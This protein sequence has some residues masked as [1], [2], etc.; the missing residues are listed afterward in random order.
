MEEARE[1]EHERKVHAED[2]EARQ[3]PVRRIAKFEQGCAR[4]EQG[5]DGVE[6]DVRHLRRACNTPKRR[7]CADESEDGDK[8]DRPRRL[9][10]ERDS[11]VEHFPDIG[12]DRRDNERRAKEEDQAL[13]GDRARVQLCILFKAARHGIE[14]RCIRLVPAVETRRE[15]DEPEQ[16][17]DPDRVV[18]GVDNECVA[19]IRL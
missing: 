16:E 1:E 12:T 3:D 13:E 19:H 9:V 5:N 6:Q 15:R 10:E 8:E 7:D 17:H 11:G 2:D 4:G 14:F 18:D